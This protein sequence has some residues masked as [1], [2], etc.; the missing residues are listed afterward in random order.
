MREQKEIVDYWATYKEDFEEPICNNCKHKIKNSAKCSAYPKAI[1]REILNNEIN[2][3]KE[4][5]GDNGIRFEP[6]EDTDA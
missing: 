2:L 6:I 4:Y 5:I 1:P 3:R